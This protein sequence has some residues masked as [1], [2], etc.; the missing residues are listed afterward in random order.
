[1][2][3]LSSNC[4]DRLIYRDRTSVVKSFIILQYMIGVPFKSEEAI[5]PESGNESWPTMNEGSQR[6]R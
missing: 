6:I 2:V 1:M 4:E 3:Y 5:S